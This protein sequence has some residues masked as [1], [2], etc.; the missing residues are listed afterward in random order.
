VFEAGIVD[1]IAIRKQNLETRRQILHALAA[2]CMQS[3]QVF[4]SRQRK[5]FFEL[6]NEAAI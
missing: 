1:E 4:A 5:Q 3:C 2:S 6:K